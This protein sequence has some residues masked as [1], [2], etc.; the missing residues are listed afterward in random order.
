MTAQTNNQPPNPQP[1]LNEFV[2]LD[3]LLPSPPIYSE[4]TP[5]LILNPCVTLERRKRSDL[6]Q[7]VSELQRQHDDH[8]ELLSRRNAELKE[9]VRSLRREMRVLAYQVARGIF[10]KAVSLI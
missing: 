5:T 8:N 6:E 10:A 4:R 3:E 9:Q 7:Y 1:R 2:H